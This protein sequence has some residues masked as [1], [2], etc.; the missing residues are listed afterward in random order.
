MARNCL[1][2]CTWMAYW[3]RDKISAMLVFTKWPLRFGLFR[4]ICVNIA[5][6]YTVLTVSGPLRH[7]FCNMLVKTANYEALS[8]VCFRLVRKVARSCYCF[9]MYVR[10]SAMEQLSNH[11]MAFHEIWYLSIFFL[12]LSRRFRFH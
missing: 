11:W 4:L 2:S 10:P 6:F 9:V 7:H 1:R 5:H 3:K 8:C 12:N